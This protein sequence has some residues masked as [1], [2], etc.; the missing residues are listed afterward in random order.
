MPSP[1]QVVRLDFRY[2]SDDAAATNVMYFGY[3]GAGAVS[4]AELTDFIESSAMVDD[5]PA[6]YVGACNTGTV[7]VTSTATDL[8]SETG[9][10][11]EHILGWTGGNTGEALPASAAV[12]VSDTILRRY[13]GGH[14]RTYML[15]GTAGDFVS[16]S[17]KDWQAEFLVNIQN[18]W[19]SF[20]A[21]FPLTIGARTWTP[22]NVS[23]WET[24]GGV[25]TLRATPLV[26]LI[27]GKVA[28]SRIC[29]QRRRLGKVGG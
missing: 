17:V 13:R 5:L 12:C 2:T 11:F 8:S 27:V 16:G 18:D 14:P 7:G 15:C 29:S 20:M 9:A 10:V 3:T 4:L 23:F 25:R 22:V 19:N 26:D 28:R 24:V 21:D 6:A 1:G